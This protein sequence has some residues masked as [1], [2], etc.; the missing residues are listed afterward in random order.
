[1]YLLIQWTFLEN[2]KFHQQRYEV[3]LPW[4]E[5]HCTVPDHFTI[6]LYRLRLHIRLLKNP[7]LLAEY[8]TI[9]QDHCN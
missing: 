7:E 4:K 6:C 1:M 2:I 8:N 9:L 3:G 5:S